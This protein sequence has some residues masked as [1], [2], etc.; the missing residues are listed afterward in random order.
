MYNKQYSIGEQLQCLVSYL[1]APFKL[2]LMLLS[3]FLLQQFCVKNKSTGFLLV[4]PSLFCSTLQSPFGT[5]S[6]HLP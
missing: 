2:F 4:L 3:V 1:K 5:L 6:Q